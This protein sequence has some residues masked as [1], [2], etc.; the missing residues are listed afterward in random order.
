MKEHQIV[1]RGGSSIVL[2]PKN[3][4]CRMDSVQSTD[5]QYTLCT[6]YLET[7]YAPVVCT[8]ISCD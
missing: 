7:F 1:K 5:I 8:H 6:T 2:Y 4:V 3:F